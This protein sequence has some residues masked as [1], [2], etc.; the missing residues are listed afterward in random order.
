MKILFIA[1][2]ESKALWDYYD[3]SRVKDV[4][5]II[6]CGDLKKEYLEFLVTM[7]GCPL[8]YVHGNHDDRFAK[9]PPEGCTCIDDKIVTVSGLRILGLGGC[10]RY[11]PYALYMYEED[12]M[13]RRIQ[14]LRRPL[15]KSGG[16]DLLVTHAPARGHGD[17]EDLPHQG[18]ECFNTLLETYHPSHMVY[19]H[20]HKEYGAT[21]FNRFL[22]HPGGTT[23]VNAWEYVILDI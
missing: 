6:S 5:L 18:F 19:G 2:R 14:K 11:N 7:V 15:K 3:K 12:E 4:D 9:Q 21:S 23:L 17:L 8:L 1:D 20:V 10:R 16:F 22:Q 13:A